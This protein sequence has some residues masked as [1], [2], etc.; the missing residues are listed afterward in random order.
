MFGK[1]IVNL[2]CVFLILY[3]SATF[4]SPT[5][6][7][8]E[9]LAHKVDEDSIH[10]RARPPYRPYQCIYPYAW[11]RRECLGGNDPRAWQDV[12]GWATFATR[13]ETDY[14][15]K[16]GRCPPN[17]YCLDT[18]NSDG[19]PFISC[20]GKGKRTLRQFDPQAGTS[21]PKRARTQLQN[22]QIEYSVKIDHDIKGASVAA[23]VTSKC[24]PANIHCRMPLCSCWELFNKFR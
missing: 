19:K 5:A 17:T 22:T 4:A 1:V 13:F 20:L 16:P 15:N 9:A 3:T 24:S 21:N 8:E 7:P 18:Y 6:Q 10:A 14:D 12:C 11:I 2:T 23:V